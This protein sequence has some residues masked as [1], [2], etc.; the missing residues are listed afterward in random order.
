M[1]TCD[2][3]PLSAA[4]FACPDC[5]TDLCDTCCNEAPGRTVRCLSL[6]HI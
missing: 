1:I 3:H 2:Y 5:N 4:T 6:I